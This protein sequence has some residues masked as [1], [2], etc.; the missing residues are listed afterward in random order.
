MINQYTGLT[1]Y[2]NLWVTS[3]YYDYQDI[4]REVDSVIGNGRCIL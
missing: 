4:A 1:E 2:Y 3:G